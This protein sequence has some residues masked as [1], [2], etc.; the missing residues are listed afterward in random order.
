MELKDVMSLV[1]LLV[2]ISV[3]VMLYKTLRVSIKTT[4]LQVTRDLLREHSKEEMTEKRRFMR[5]ELPVILEKCQKEKKI[6][7][8]ISSSAEKTTSELINYYEFIG[9][10]IRERY[11]PKKFLVHG[12]WASTIIF[13]EIIKDHLNWIRLPETRAPDWAED[14]KYFYEVCKGYQNRKYPSWTPESKRN[15]ED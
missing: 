12:L 5:T 4:Y 15:R 3:A 6:L 8:E 11:F 1:A 2:S 7:K 13:W 9:M 10:M 14:F